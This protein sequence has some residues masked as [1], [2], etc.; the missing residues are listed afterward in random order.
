MHVVVRWFYT[1]M[2]ISHWECQLP[3]GMSVFDGSS[4][5]HV[6]LQCSMSRSPMGHRSG[7]LDSDEACRGHQAFWS[8]IKHVEVSDGSSIWHDGLRW[9]SD[10][11]NIFVNFMHFAFVFSLLFLL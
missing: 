1:V 2:S 5:R 3:M 8:P 10:N 7:M 4:I 11:N 9:V 6:G